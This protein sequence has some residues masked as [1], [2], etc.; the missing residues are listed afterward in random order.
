MGVLNAAGLVAVRSEDRMIWIPSR[1]WFPD[2]PQSGHQR[3][4]ERAQN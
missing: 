4:I 3:Q 2:N 1:Y